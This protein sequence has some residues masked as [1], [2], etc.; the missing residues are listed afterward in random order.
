MLF[1]L[2]D[3]VTS[4]PYVSI[5]FVKKNSSIPRFLF[6]F[7][8]IVNFSVWVCVFGVFSFFFFSTFALVICCFLL[9]LIKR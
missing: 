2:E 7:F 8:V 5:V 6:H 3:M 9:G 4:F 1:V